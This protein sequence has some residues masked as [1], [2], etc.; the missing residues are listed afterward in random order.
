MNDLTSIEQVEKLKSRASHMCD[1]YSPPL[2]D[3]RIHQTV[4]SIWPY[5]N[6]INQGVNNFFYFQVQLFQITKE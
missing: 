2:H 4:Q 3:K 6:Y 1:T 5:C